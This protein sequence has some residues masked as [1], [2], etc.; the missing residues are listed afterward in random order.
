MNLPSI[1]LVDPE[2][3]NDSGRAEFLEWLVDHDWEILSAWQRQ[4]ADSNYNKTS[5]SSKQ[6]Q[7]IDQM[8]MELPHTY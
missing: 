7:I 4:F 3:Y 2:S 5:F 8:S 1:S 6:R